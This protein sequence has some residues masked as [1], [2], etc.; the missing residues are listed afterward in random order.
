[1]SYNIEIRKASANGFFTPAEARNYYGKYSRQGFTVHWWNSRDRIKDSD[2]DNIV[3]MFLRNSANAVAPTVNYVLSNAKI[4]YLVSPDN[5][6]WTSNNG[7]ATTISCEFSP[8]LNAEGYK[9]AGW[10]ISELESRY[11]RVLQLYPHNHWIGTQCP[12]DLNIGRMRAEAD[13]W[14]RGDYANK[15]VPQ[16][17]PVPTPA[18]VPT[19]VVSNWVKWDTPVEYIVNKQP[20]HLWNF[21]AINWAMKSVK[22]FNKGERIVVVGQATNTK[23]KRDYYLTSYSFSKKI[24][25]GFNPADLSV[26]VAPRPQP[27]PPEEPPTPPVVPP[28]EPPTPE[29]QTQQ[30]TDDINAIKRFFIAIGALMA[31]IFG[32]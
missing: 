15:P 19:P 21:N 24:T 22:Q 11:G 13:K 16:P 26:Y 5:V 25:N 27:T 29:E 8:W 7:N 2:H 14:K 3:N 17:I 18:P 23:L 32:K 10:L 28:V 9:K 4:T 1:M 31:K 30:N 12:G 6:T 20:T